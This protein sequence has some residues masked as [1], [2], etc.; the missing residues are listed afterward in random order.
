MFS[1]D[2]VSSDA[3][4]DMPPSTQ[5]L[6]FHL[7][8]RADDDGFVQP[9]MIMRMIG[10]NED[11]LKIL[12]SKRFVLQ[13]ESGV[14]VIKHWLIHNLIRADIYKETLY[15][16]EKNTLGLKDNGAYTELKDG[17]N[18]L[19]KIETPDWLKRRRGELR[20]A[21]VPSTARRLGK[22]RLGKVNTTASTDAESKKKNYAIH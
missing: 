2:I 14:L 6:Y 21:N 12:T 9:K 3:F 5:A 18:R 19:K 8:M 20:T 16:D 4:L 11:D 17:I 13:F 22:V 7:G 10:S 1:P 15:L